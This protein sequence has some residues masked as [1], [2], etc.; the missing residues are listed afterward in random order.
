MLT[1]H[2][3]KEPSATNWLCVYSHKDVF[4]NPYDGEVDANYDLC[5]QVDEQF[6]QHVQVDATGIQKDWNVYLQLQVITHK[7][8]KSSLKRKLSY[9]VTTHTN[10][11]KLVALGLRQRT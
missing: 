9:K 1:D 11:N 6:P 4:L 2:N 3:A 8:W 7:P 10:Q 5:C